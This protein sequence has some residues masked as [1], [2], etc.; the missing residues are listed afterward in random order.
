[1]KINLTVEIADDEI[2]RL[3]LAL[4]LPTLT[5]D[6][7]EAIRQEAAEMGAPVTE[8]QEA[9]MAA[10]TKKRKRRTKAEMEAARAED[11]A[12]RGHVDEPV[13]EAGGLFEAL[14]GEQRAPATAAIEEPPFELNRDEVLEQVRARAKAPGGREWLVNHVIC[15]GKYTSISTVPN[16]VLVAALAQEAIALAA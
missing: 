10:E 7:Q 13:A 5:A 2:R 15:G 12:I 8:E 9:E 4:P 1:M 6:D 14:T 11:A 16:A 3:F